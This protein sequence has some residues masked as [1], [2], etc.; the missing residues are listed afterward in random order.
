[1]DAWLVDHRRDLLA[2]GGTL[3]DH[4]D[5]LLALLTEPEQRQQLA[6]AIDTAGE[7]LTSQPRV[8]YAG[9]L[10]YSMFLLRP[11]GPAV[12][13]YDPVVR[14]GI[15]LGTQLRHGFDQLHQG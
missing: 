12:T 1:M 8:G 13:V 7:L 15:D 9:A 4:R 11:D 2:V 14:E 3:I 5:Y 6:E 10:A